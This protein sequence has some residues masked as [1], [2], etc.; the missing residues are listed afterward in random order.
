[1]NW[2]QWGTGMVIF[3]FVGV[4]TAHAYHPRDTREQF[5]THVEGGYTHVGTRGGIVIVLTT[6]S[7][8]TPG[9]GTLTLEGGQSRVV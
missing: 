6:G 3:T 9:T 2:K 4:Q 7:S 1:M 8:I 5:H